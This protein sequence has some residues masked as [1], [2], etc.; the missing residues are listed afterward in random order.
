M[1][2]ALR[3]L[4]LLCLLAACHHAAA[5]QGGPSAGAYEITYQL[6]IR[7]RTSAT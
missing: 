6:G 2:A 4:A 7:P 5:A 1:R 3:A